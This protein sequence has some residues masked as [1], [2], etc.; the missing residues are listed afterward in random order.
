[1]KDEVGIA[2]GV[3]Y[4]D[5]QQLIGALERDLAVDLSFVDD[6][7]RPLVEALERDLAEALAGSPRNRAGKNRGGGGA[8]V[9]RREAARAWVSSARPSP[10]R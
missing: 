3:V 8:R 7:V 10:P 5:G 4:D 9:F 6:D 2:D 1:M